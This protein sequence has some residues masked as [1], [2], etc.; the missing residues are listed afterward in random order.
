MGVEFKYKNKSYSLFNVYHPP[1]RLEI[2][3]LLELI[4][5]LKSRAEPKSKLIILGD[6]NIDI[7]ENKNAEFVNQM[8]GWSLPPLF[9]CATRITDDSATALDLIFTNESTLFGGPVES[10]VSDHYLNFAAFPGKNT[11]VKAICRPDHSQK[12]LQNLKEWLQKV[13]FTGVLN[14]REITAFSKFDSIMK[15]ASDACCPMKR[16]KVNHKYHAPW[17]TRGFLTSH[18]HKDRLKQ[19]ARKKNSKALWE[20]FKKYNSVY[21]RLCRVAR[22]RYYSNEFKLNKNDSRAMWRLANSVTGREKKQGGITNFP[23]CRNEKEISQVFNTYYS[24]IASEIISKIPTSEKSH[25]EYLPADKPK[26]KLIFQPIFPSDVAKILDSMKNKSSYGPDKISNKI[27]KVIKDE[28]KLPLCHLI[29]L[30]F[31]HNYVPESWKI[32]RICPIHKGGDR[33]L[34]TNF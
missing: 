25:I 2:T 30:S 14:D 23:G 28:I 18:R 33:N 32:S 5:V 21:S 12:A 17:F 4:S 34:T 26:S 27:L 20:K 7:L 19:K 8:M 6:F 3:K 31:I 13:D 24:N 15:K 9:T 10:S 1:K 16:S 22:H 11:P 29:N